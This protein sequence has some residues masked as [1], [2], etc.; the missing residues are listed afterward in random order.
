MAEAD[1][2][3]RILKMIEERKI[4]AEEGLRLLAAKGENAVGATGAGPGR[5]AGTGRWLRIRIT[6]IASGQSKASVQIP[7]DLI[8]AGMK[9]G[10]RFAPEVAGV[11]MSNV[12]EAVRSGATGKIIDVTDDKGGE[13][14]EIAVE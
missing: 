1:E 6:D 3:L 5:G 8:D 2:R 7:I 14:I 13:H 9:I 11:D 4:T 10:A 12:M